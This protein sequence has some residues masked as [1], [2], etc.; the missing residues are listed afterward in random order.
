M[1]NKE[2]LRKQRYNTIIN[3]TSSKQEKILLKAIDV[4]KEMLIDHFPNI[5]LEWEQSWKLVDIIEILKLEF[6]DLSFA[7]A[8]EKS[9][10]KPDGGFLYIL[11]DKGERYPILITEK[12]N[13]GTNDLR[14]S[15]G[16]PIQAKGNAI[17][18]LGKNVIG[19]R[20]ALLKE[21][22]FPFICFGDG[23]DFAEN[24][25]IIDRVITIA[26]FGDLNKEHLHNQGMF[27]RGTFYFRKEPWTQKEMQELSYSIACKSVHYYISK[28]GEESF[29]PKTK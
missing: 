23:C 2:D 20:A 3:K 26:M 11:N 22:I 4:V 10:M 14:K 8:L 17:E 27:N 16:K 1:S 12:K 6:P 19:L 7:S 13:Q 18:R 5:K 25:S 15:E 9:K 24:S 29:F 28:Y 21:N